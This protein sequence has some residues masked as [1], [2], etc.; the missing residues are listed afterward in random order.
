MQRTGRKV[1]YSEEELDEFYPAWNCL[2]DAEFEHETL[3]LRDL[4]LWANEE[5]LMNGTSP[6][7]PDLDRLSDTIREKISASRPGWSSEKIRAFQFYCLYHEGREPVFN[8][9]KAAREAMERKNAAWREER[10]KK[11]SDGA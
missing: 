1:V 6:L 2:A 3:R 9:D 11:R 5:A 10:N 4:L 8:F 7:R